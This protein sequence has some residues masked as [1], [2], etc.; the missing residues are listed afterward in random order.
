MLPVMY[1]ELKK[2]FTKLLGLIYKQDAIPND[3]DF[4]KLD[5]K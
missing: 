2:V 1:E 4:K 5:K 3:K